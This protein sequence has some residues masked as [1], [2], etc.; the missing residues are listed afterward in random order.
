MLCNMK[1]LVDQ[2][3]NLEMMTFQKLDKKLVVTIHHLLMMPGTDCVHEMHNTYNDSS[4]CASSSDDEPQNEVRQTKPRRS[5][6]KKPDA[7]ILSD[8]ASPPGVEP[9]S[10]NDS[11]VEDASSAHE[12]AREGNTFKRVGRP[13]KRNIRNIVRATTA[14]EV[15]DK[16]FWASQDQL[17]HLRAQ[18]QQTAEPAEASVSCTVLEK[19]GSLINVLRQYYQL[20][21]KT[22]PNAL[23]ENFLARFNNELEIQEL[24]KD[25]IHVKSLL[26]YAICKNQ[27]AI[28]DPRCKVYSLS[29]NDT[30]LDHTNSSSTWV[31]V[32]QFF[33]K[34]FEEELEPWVRKQNLR[35]Y[36]PEQIL[37]TV[38]LCAIDSDDDDDL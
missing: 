2:R 1:T 9:L 27:R 38:D 18:Q 31:S 34:H 14:D 30:G 7:S 24:V 19:V 17:T 13:N 33:F 20:N 29:T 12:K 10:E 26:E 21:K 23:V 5:R 32:A 3:H 22:C 16:R 11:S 35:E 4:D 8:D 6:H 36:K 25:F 37:E 28:D 15:S